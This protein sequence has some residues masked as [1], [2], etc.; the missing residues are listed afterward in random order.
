[1][2]F[3]HHIASSIQTSSIIASIAKETDATIDLLFL[4]KLGQS[5]DEDDEEQTQRPLAKRNWCVIQSN[6]SGYIQNVSNTGLLRVA[7]DGKTVVR[8]NRTRPLVSDRSWM[9]G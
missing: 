5:P 6:E 3:I 4:E 9:W 8:W 1:M 2:F 7:R